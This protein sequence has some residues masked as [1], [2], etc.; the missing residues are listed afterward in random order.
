MSDAALPRGA[1]SARRNTELGLLILAMLLALGAYV[2]VG[3]G[4]DGTVPVGLLGYGLVLTAAYILAHLVVRIFAPM[5]DPVFLPT[6]V[7]LAGLGFALIYRLN[8]RLATA[9]TL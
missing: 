7:L 8:P 4:I 1:G 3:L 6:A 2:L 5:A 9:Q